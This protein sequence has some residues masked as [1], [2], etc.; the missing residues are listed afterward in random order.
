MVGRIEGLVVPEDDDLTSKPTLVKKLLAKSRPYHARIPFLRALPLPAVAIVLFVALVNAVIWA[1]A[2]VVLHFHSHLITTAVLSY[3]LG[4]R[5][6][7]DADHISAIDIT[8]RRLFASGQ[9]PVT[10]GT[11]FSLG[12][13]TIVIITSI[14]VASTAAA[15]TDRFG[16]FSTTGGIIGS[17]VSAVFLLVL[18]GMNCYLLT[19]LVAELRFYSASPLGAKYPGISDADPFA[20]ASGPMARLLKGLFKLIDAP[21][22]MYPLGVLFGLG[23]DTSS[24]IALLGIS[25]V[26][27]ARGTSLWLILIFPI[28]FTAGM[29]LLDTLDG[30]AMS[31]LYASARLGKDRVAVA[32]YQTVLTGITVLVAAVIGTVQVLVMAD[33]V[34]SPTGKFWEGVEALGDHYDVVG[35]AICGSFVVFGGLAAVLYK[36]WR[37]RL[38]ARRRKLGVVEVEEEIAPEV[39]EPLV[40][41]PD[42]KDKKVDIEGEAAVV[43][44][45][46]ATKVRQ[47]E[48][49]DGPSGS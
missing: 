47:D 46:D 35:G 5:H 34:A 41:G 37:R 2:G 11:F 15:V 32:Y 9:R 7:L 27:S 44:A 10:V 29:C 23:F 42:S 18:G 36:P 22:K 8:T 3:T 16:S 28:L 17:T 6:A 14:V 33:S 40:A 21:W 4:L 48:V 45:K 12:H 13:S 25:A 20:N 19:R 24:E 30:A 39:E 26:S 1:V 31:A 43:V 49:H 38:D